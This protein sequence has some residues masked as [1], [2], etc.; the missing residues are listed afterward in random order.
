MRYHAYSQ[1]LPSHPKLPDLY[2]TVVWDNDGNEIERLQHEG[3]GD[4]IELTLK[5]KIKKSYLGIEPPSFE[6][7]NR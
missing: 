7:V 3:C 4:G 5:Y 2:L 1:A 6:R